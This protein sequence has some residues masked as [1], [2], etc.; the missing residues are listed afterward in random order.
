MKNKKTLYILIPAVLI[1]WGLIVYKIFS[2]SDDPGTDTLLPIAKKTL[3]VTDSVDK[4]VIHANYPDPFLK[5]KTYKASGTVPAGNKVANVANS[6][7]KKTT[8]VV[9]TPPVAK[10]P[11]IRYDG[12]IINKNS[13][14]NVITS[15]S[16]HYTKLYE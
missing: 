5:D 6:D 15:Y 2:W 10:W 13:G 8:V 14:E 4:S 9:K 3:P 7:S 12:L 11:K 1:I 16:I